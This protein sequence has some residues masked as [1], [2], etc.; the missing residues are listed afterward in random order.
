MTLVEFLPVTSTVS[1]SSPLVGVEVD[2]PTTTVVEF[3][4]P[5]LSAMSSSSA[6]AVAAAAAVV[7]TLDE[8]AGDNASVISSKTAV[9]IAN[10]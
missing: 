6:S 9:D 7:E 4:S 1:A 2:E 5:P 8:M 10:F 3:P